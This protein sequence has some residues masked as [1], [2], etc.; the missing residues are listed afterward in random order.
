MPRGWRDDY[1]ATNEGWSAHT[2]GRFARHFFLTMCRWSSWLMMAGVTLVLFIACSNV[3]NLLLARAA[4]RRREFAVRAAIGAGRGRIVRQLLTESVVLG[5]ASVPLG[6]VL[7]ADRHAADRVDACPSD[8]VPAL[9]PVGG[10][11]ALARLRRRRRSR[12]RRWSSAC[13]RRC[14][15]RAEICTRASRKARAATAPADRCCAARSSS[16]RCRSRS[17]RSW[18]RCSSFGRSSISIP[19][20]LGFDPKPLMTMRFY[21]T[22]EPYEPRDAKLRRVEDVVRR[23]E[24]LPGV[25]AAFASNLIPISGGGG[26]G[27]DR[28]RRTRDREGRRVAHLLHRRD[29]ALPRRRSASR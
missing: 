6:I 7:A 19:I 22:G 13:F 1:P 14:R 27:D 25:Q 9:H 16:R 3:A 12:R 21:M 26:G 2:S 29:A 24:A 4:G 17:W 18:A 5:L 8:Q 20:E 10:R 28:S 11:L 15:C 23:V